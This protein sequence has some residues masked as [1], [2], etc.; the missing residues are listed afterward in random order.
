MHQCLGGHDEELNSVT[1][2]VDQRDIPRLL[3]VGAVAVVRWGALKRAPEGSWLARMLGVNRHRVL[4]PY[5]S[6]PLGLDR[7]T[8]LF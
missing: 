1:I 6:A 4:T 8:R 2:E 3:I 5:W 7:I